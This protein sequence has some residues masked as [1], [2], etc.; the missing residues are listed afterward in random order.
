[1][2]VHILAEAE[3]TMGPQAGKLLVSPTK[4]SSLNPLPSIKDNYWLCA[5][6]G[7]SSGHLFLG[8][9]VPEW[10][11]LW[12]EIVLWDISNLKKELPASCC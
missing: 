9:W 5:A 3:A 2:G 8:K 11:P 7:S 12:L 10:S 6:S 1:M 4:N